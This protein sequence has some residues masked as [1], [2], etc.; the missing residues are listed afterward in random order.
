MGF[1]P[2]TSAFFV[3]LIN[4]SEIQPLKRES[5]CNFSIQLEVYPDRDR[6]LEEV[7]FCL[8]DKTLIYPQRTELLFDLQT[9]TD[10]DDDNKQ[11]SRYQ[12]SF[13]LTKFCDGAVSSVTVVFHL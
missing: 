7:P 5:T 2:A 4:I 1:I 9:E 8:K 3:E 6:E 10:N 12:F 13:D 11:D